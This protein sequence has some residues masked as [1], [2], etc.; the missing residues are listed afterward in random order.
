MR[1]EAEAAGS[2]F[3]TDEEVNAWIEELRSED[4][5]VEE[6]YRLREKKNPLF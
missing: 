6:A 5:R 2:H 3:M 1:R 4:D